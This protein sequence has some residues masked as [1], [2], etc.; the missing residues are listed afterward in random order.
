MSQA[1]A[2][3]RRRTA[4]PRIPLFDNRTVK[5]ATVLARADEVME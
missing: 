5:S 3:A 1:A 2:Q 4:L